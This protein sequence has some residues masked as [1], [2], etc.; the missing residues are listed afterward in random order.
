MG[1]WS[2]WSA[3]LLPS[4]ATLSF[5]SKDLDGIS[6][7]LAEAQIPQERMYGTITR[8]TKVSTGGQKG[9]Q[10][11]RRPERQLSS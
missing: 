10:N 8:F 1:P 6:S 2:F 4:H 3:T 9:K 11:K 5:P 7:L